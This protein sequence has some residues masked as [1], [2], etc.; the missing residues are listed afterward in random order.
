MKKKI[1]SLLCAVLVCVGLFALTSCDEDTASKLPT[2][3]KLEAPVIV[4]TDNV[5]EWDANGKA[6][7]FEISLDGELSYVENTVTQKVLTDGQTVK[8]RA[9]GDGI[10]YAT[11]EWSNSVKYAVSASTVLTAPINTNAPDSP[12]ATPDDPDNTDA[13][14]IPDVTPDDPDKTDTPDIPDATTE[15]PGTSKPPEIPVA[16]PVRAEVT[17]EG[18]NLFDEASEKYYAN[19][20]IEASLSDPEAVFTKVEVFEGHYDSSEATPVYSG[21]FEGYADVRENILSDHDYIV[22]VYYKGSDGVEKYGSSYAYV[23]SLDVPWVMH[24]YAYGLLSDGIIGFRF[25]ADGKYNMSNLTLKITDEES[26]E[27]IAKDA[28]ELINN[29]GII[30]ELRAK[31]DT[32][33]RWT[34]GDEFD[35]V[36]R[37]LDRLERTKDTVD[38]YYSHLTKAEWET[39]ASGSTY[40]YEVKFG[41]GDEF[42][43]GP[44]GM[45]YAVL[46]DLQNRRVD[47]NSLKFELCADMDFNNG[48][49]TEIGRSLCDGWFDVIP[50]I[51]EGDYL[52]SSEF[53]LREDD[54]VYLETMS[55]NNLGNESHR[56]LG[57]VNQ[58]VLADGYKILEVLWTQDA[59]PS[60]VDEEAWLA[61]VIDALK[62][63]D[64][65]ESV[66]PLGDMSPIEF[67]LN[68][69]TDLVG[70]YQIRY[71]Y[72]MFGKTYTE[73]YP[74]EWAGET[75]THYIVGKLPTASININTEPVDS[76][77]EWWI[78]LPEGFGWN[79]FDIEIRDAAGNVKTYN[80]YNYWEAGRLSANDSVRI[81]LLD[82]DDVPY[83]LDG[84]WSEWFVCTPAKLRAPEVSYHYFSQTEVSVTWGWVWE[85]DRYGYT[86]NGG[87][88]TVLTEP[89]DHIVAKTGDV[90]RI[91]A[92]APG[93]SNFGSSEYTE[94][95][96]TDNRTKLNKPT[97]TVS[98]K[99]EMAFVKITQDTSTEGVIY[100][101]YDPDGNRHI[102]RGDE[103][104]IKTQYKGTYRVVAASRDYA[105]Y[106]ESEAYVFTL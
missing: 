47:D 27:Y 11:S 19:L 13:P 29:P 39:L 87:A 43:A 94:T 104:V 85:Y 42:F 32:L 16:P 93:D 65:A 56:M 4:L 64:G 67:K 45:Y 20:R 86:V 30:N 28:L 90:V 48:E 38:G 7:R 59:P 2:P 23:Y 22:R 95:V 68:I 106:S 10:K 63:G 72:K 81:R 61:D 80:Q 82:P 77:G 35:R 102:Y 3:E 34:E 12:D 1:F 98:I 57:Y 17:V 33:D 79:W 15:V 53:S 96:I 70:E 62:R 5:A 89:V 49:P 18:D 92:I 71:T 6:E 9:I 21:S 25:S 60:D 101:I 91:R 99:S 54:T 36:Y 31:L 66:F 14:D 74:Y 8:V 58:I 50:S 37:K 76:Y 75:V 41:D 78:E 83:Y 24:E 40:L 84:D 51:G 100:Y 44:D 88:E 105:N 52:F 55:R 69:N 103:Y 46:R 97:V 73:D 26:A